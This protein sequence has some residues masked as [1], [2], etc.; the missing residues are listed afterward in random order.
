MLESYFR[1]LSCVS[2]VAYF[3]PKTYV[4]DTRKNR[5]IETVLLSTQN[6]Y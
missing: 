1:S 4:V 2:P 5:L 3:L 6:R